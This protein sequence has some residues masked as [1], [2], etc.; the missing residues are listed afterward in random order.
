VS[1][2]ASAASRAVGHAAVDRSRLAAALVG[3]V[4]AGAAV[5]G[6]HGATR[7]TPALGYDARAHIA[8]A[9][10]LDAEGRLPTEE[11]SYEF[12]TPPAFA[13][14][15]VRLQR[16]V[17]STGER[18][19]EL[20]GDS[21]GPG[22]R[23]AWL[24][25]AS[26]AAGLL[27]RFGRGQPGWLAG[28]GLAVLVV[29][30]ALVRADATAAGLRWTAGQFLSIVWLG[31]LIVVAWLLAREL[32]PGRPLL[33][34]LGALATAAVPI[35]LRLGTMFHPEMQFAFFG[36]LAVLV[37]VRAQRAGWTLRHAVVLGIVLG[38]AALTR[39][40][41]AAVAAGVGLAAALAGRRRALPFLAVA[42][43][44][45]LLVAG[46]WWARQIDRYGNPLESN[47]DRYILEG[48]QPRS[49]YV[50]APVED[51]VLRPY[52]PAF[53]GELWPQFH[54]DLWSDWFGAQHAFWPNEPGTTTRVF[55]S[56]QSVLGLIASGL[57][58]AGLARFGGRA[59]LRIAPKR[60]PQ[61]SDFAWT[62]FLLLALVTWIAFAVQ[63]VRFPQAGG[64]PIKASYLLY[65]TPIFALAAVAAGSRLWH[66]SHAWRLP[67][68]TFALLYAASY[69]GFVF[70]AFPLVPR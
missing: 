67:L 23:A 61:E 19:V 29:L 57:A 34:A 38:L 11:E 62:A 46:F 35:V 58:I 14:L 2:I 42:A 21:S 63:L 55:L 65:L 25:A 40:T 69:A 9:E 4:V 31:A 51:L 33:A 17:D 50:S 59:L 43:G 3:L 1:V 70:T 66:R 49:F 52:R 68:L 5:L 30:A 8:Y 39:P 64:D 28:L 37:S 27:V 13:W 10:I 18:A 7:S 6:W 22:V 53:A 44:V 54:A 48:G 60:D 12:T 32:W 45:M 26:V 15:A 24:V 36:A 20:V 16:V 56:S 47:L 41:A